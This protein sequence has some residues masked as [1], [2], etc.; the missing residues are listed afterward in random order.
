MAR[1]ER[2]GPGAGAGGGWQTGLHPA[3]PLPGR[4]AATRAA[5]AKL[6]SLRRGN[7]TLSLTLIGNPALQAEGKIRLTGLRDPVDGEW[8]LQRVEHQ[9]DGRGFVTRIEAETPNR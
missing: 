8:L 6:E 1:P 3:P 2:R 9:F 5:S 4:E 7:A